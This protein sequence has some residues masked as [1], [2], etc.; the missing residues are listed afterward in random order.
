MLRTRSVGI[1]RRI[2]GAT[3]FLL[4]IA[5][6]LTC[7]AQT[8]TQVRTVTIDKSGSGTRPDKHESTKTSPET[9]GPAPSSHTLLCDLSLLL[10]NDDVGKVR[11][12]AFNGP[13]GATVNFTT[14]Q[15][16]SG[17]LGMSHTATGPFTASIVVP[18]PLDG[19]GNGQSEIFYVQGL[20]LGVTVLYATSVEM[21]NTTLLEY[22]VLPQ[23]NCP[24]I[25]VVP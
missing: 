20:Q 19:S 10:I 14:T 21:G 11:I 15:T 1:G 8:Q 22:T 25:P 2:A 3:C 13:A 7:A 24:P 23:C 18:V 17:V 9:A 6:L 12:V 4:I 5:P 16:V